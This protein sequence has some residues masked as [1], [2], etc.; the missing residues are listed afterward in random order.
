MTALHDPGHHAAGANDV[1]D[2]QTI[3]LRGV[4]L[5]ILGAS[6]ALSSRES[7]RLSIAGFSVHPYLAPLAIVILMNGFSAF[8]RVPR[9]VVL[10]MT[11]F[12][13][14]FVIL[15]LPTGLGTSDIVKLL[16]FDLTI[17]TIAVAP[18]TRADVRLGIAGFVTAITTVSVIALL[19]Q[20]SGILGIEPFGEV[21][22][23]NSYSLYALPAILLAGYMLYERNATR[24]FRLTMVACTVI[25]TVTIFSTGNRSGWIGVTLIGVML[26]SRGRRL[27][28]VGIIVVLGIGAY[29]V[30]TTFGSTE[31]FLFRLSRPSTTVASDETRTDLISAGIKLGRENLMFG[32]GPPAV[33]VRLGQELGAG[34]RI[35]SHNLFASIWAGGGLALSLAFVGL[36]GSFWRKPIG[37]QSKAPIKRRTRAPAMGSHDLGL[38][39][40]TVMLFLVRGFFAAD[41]LTIPGFMYGFGFALAFLVLDLAQSTPFDEAVIAD[42]DPARRGEERPARGGAKRAQASAPVAYRHRDLFAEERAR[43]HGHERTEQR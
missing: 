35:A 43:R 4:M 42:L 9:P 29:L 26:L 20:R 38:L 3:T 31:A 18:R 1:P 22:N 10:G 37:W 40:M 28:D 21:G 33:E 12:T 6:I 11:A 5:C 8:G 30:L 27:R 7:L 13:T 2:Q 24:R 41:I 32:V 16:T 39:R 25:M 34:Q 15:S 36:M 17:A 19:T 14:V 23:K